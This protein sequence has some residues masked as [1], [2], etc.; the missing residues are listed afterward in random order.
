[1]AN[2]QQR[3]AQMIRESLINE[4][5]KARNKRPYVFLS[6]G[7]DSN[8]I[9]FAALE[10]GT[11]PITLS[12]HMEGV[13]S[14]DF[15]AAQR[16]A[17]HFGLEFIEVVLPSDYTRLKSDVLTMAERYKCVQKNEFECSWPMLYSFFHVKR[18]AEANQ[19]KR[20]VTFT[21]Q[22]ADLMYLSSKKASIHYKDRPDVWRTEGRAN[23]HRT[24]GRILPLMAQDAGVRNIKPWDSEEILQAFLGTSWEDV[25]KPRQKEPSR[26]A[27]EDYFKQIRVYNH[28]NFQLG[29]TKI[30]EHFEQLLG[31]PEF[32]PDN[33]YKSVVGVYNELARRF[34]NEIPQREEDE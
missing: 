9:L 11:R 18:H 16:T 32:N 15:R 2:R 8:C 17:E 21:G 28:Q 26:M 10:A 27:F 12:F 4:I 19:I 13:N 30:A 25:N 29:D 31:D 22:G 33:R 1:M 34:G 14:R 7:V 5:K 3:C 6:G 20:P 23:P 24:Q